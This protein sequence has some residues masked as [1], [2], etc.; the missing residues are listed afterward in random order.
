MQD[1][2]PPIEGLPGECFP[3]RTRKKEFLRGKPRLDAES[4]TFDRYQDM[5]RAFAA[6]VRWE[7]ENPYTLDYELTLFRTLLTCC[8]VKI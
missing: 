2:T 5:M 8:G 7:T 1:S 6:M 4:E 3:H